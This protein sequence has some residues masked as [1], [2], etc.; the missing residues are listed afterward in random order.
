MAFSPSAAPR[1]ELGRVGVVC[2][3]TY[4]Y[5]EPRA[6]ANIL[7]PGSERSHPSAPFSTSPSLTPDQT[8]SNPHHKLQQNIIR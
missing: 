3:V 4:S 6:R 2:G 7:L 1:F 8:A 5:M